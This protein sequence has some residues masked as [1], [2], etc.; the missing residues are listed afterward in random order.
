MILRI[1]GRQFLYPELEAQCVL[2]GMEKN[3]KHRW[4]EFIAKE[5]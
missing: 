1:R 4:A 2:N 5:S 3:V